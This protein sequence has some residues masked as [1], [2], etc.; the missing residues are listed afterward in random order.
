M[1]HEAVV[2]KYLC[3]IVYICLPLSLPIQVHNINK[4]IIIIMREY[5]SQADLFQGYR[6]IFIKTYHSLQKD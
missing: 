5:L 6:I 3:V 1:D 4:I 2:T